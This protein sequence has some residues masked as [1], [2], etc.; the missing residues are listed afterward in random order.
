MRLLNPF[1]NVLTFPLNF[2]SGFTTIEGL[3]DTTC[4][5]LEFHQPVRRIQDPDTAE[6]IDKFVAKLRELKLVQ[7]PFQVVCQF[8]INLFR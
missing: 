6:K 5:E 4:E 1:R 2:F 3:I 7:E 8:A